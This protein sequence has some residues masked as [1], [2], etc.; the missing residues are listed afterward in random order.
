MASQH[1]A[2]LQLLM[3]LQRLVVTLTWAMQMVL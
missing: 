3:R 1:Q 2:Q